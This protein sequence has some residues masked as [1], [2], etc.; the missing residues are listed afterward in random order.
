[1]AKANPHHCH[2]LHSTSASDLTH[3]VDSECRSM[4]YVPS[5][6]VSSIRVWNWRLADLCRLFWE[7]PLRHPDI[8]ASKSIAFH[9]LHHAILEMELQQ[10]ALEEWMQ[11]PDWW[12]SSGDTI[13][14]QNQDQDMENEETDS[15]TPSITDAPVSFHQNVIIHYNGHTQQ[16]LK[17]MVH[18]IGTTRNNIQSKKMTQMLPMRLQS[19]RHLGTYNPTY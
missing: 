18:N 19:H 6:L 10:P 3:L 11:A 5:V 13:K 4:C 16:N 15:A 9:V 17:D 14:T 1:M 2:C 8:Q 7:C 12:Q